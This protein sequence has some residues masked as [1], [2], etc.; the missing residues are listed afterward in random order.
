MNMIL[1]KLGYAVLTIFIII[2]V[3]FLL[4]HLMPGEPIINL[5]GQEEYYYLLDHDPA[6]L[7]AMKEKYGLNDGLGV[8]YLKYL[9]SIVSLDFGIAYSNRQPVVQNVAKAMK[10]T[11]LLSVPT[12]ILGGLL[13]CLLGTLAGWRPG[14]AFDRTATPIFLFLH[15]I[16]SNCLSLILLIVFAYRLKWFPING[17]VSPGP[18]GIEKLFSYLHHMILP[19]F[20]LVTGR[21]SGNFLLMKSA[22][23][24]VRKEDY[25]TTAVAKGMSDRTV[26]FRHAMKNALV[27]YSTSI[28]MQLGWILSGAVIVESIFGWKGMGQL[29]LNAVHHKDFPTAQLCFL[30]TAVSVVMANWLSDVVNIRIDPRI[31]EHGYE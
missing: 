24:Q 28:V 3:S 25:L 13:G 22:V 23:L 29:M 5:V 21:T 27:P 9:K 16:P 4:I 20:I 15:T 19:L 11:L 1:K 6:Q 14:G 26:L 18:E 7:D 12:W 17:M 30:M 8:Q 31:E 10:N 2:T